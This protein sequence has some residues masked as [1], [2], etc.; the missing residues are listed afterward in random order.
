MKDFI[1]EKFE[2]VD[3]NDSVYRYKNNL[4]RNFS[5]FINPIQLFEGIKNGKE[6][7]SDA[8]ILQKAFEAQLES[9]EI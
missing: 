8:K 1:G 6:S 9:I 3:Y 4:T 5:Q 2:I 7:I